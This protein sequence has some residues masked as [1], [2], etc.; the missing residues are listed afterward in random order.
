VPTLPGTWK[1]IAVLCIVVVVFAGFVPVIAS[2]VGAAI[3]VPLGQAFLVVVVTVIR[4]Q[5]FRCDERPVSL[6]ALLASRAPPI[7]SPLA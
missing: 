2:T 3:L 1:A 7:L 6:L 4:R 5:A